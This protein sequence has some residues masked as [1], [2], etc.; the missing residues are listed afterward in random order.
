MKFYLIINNNS[1]KIIISGANGCGKTSLFRVLSS[2]WPLY[3][4][5]L[6]RPSV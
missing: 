4:G 3:E 2:L 6:Y 1:I 5:K